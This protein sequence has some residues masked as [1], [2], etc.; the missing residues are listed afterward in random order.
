MISTDVSSFAA[1]NRS[2]GS[3]SRANPI[4]L[5]VCF[6]HEVVSMKQAI[7][8]YLQTA[9]QVA[10]IQ[11]KPLEATSSAFCSTTWLLAGGVLA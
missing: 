2:S 11:T 5:K 1:H 4:D 6:F 10:D 9:E 3:S 8:K 7:L